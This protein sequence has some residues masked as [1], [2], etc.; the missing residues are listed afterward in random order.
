MVN[1]L[2]ILFVTLLHMATSTTYYV[3][4]DHYPLHNFTNSNTFALQHYLNNTCTSEYFISHNRLHFLPGQYYSSSNL[5][6]KDIHSFAITG[7]GINQS[8][9][10]CSSPASIIVRNSGIFTIQNITLI[11]C[12]NL[13]SNQ[14]YVSA[15]TTLLL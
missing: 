7:D 8:V 1:H 15:C 12:T 6:F 9:I 13:S 2:S 4:P 5:V 10:I 3:I 11:D 14:L